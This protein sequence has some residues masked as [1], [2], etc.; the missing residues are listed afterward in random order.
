MY[1]VARVVGSLSLPLIG[2]NGCFLFFRGIVE[3]CF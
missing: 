3:A 2:S 1:N